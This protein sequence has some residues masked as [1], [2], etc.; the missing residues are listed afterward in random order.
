MG[1][2]L[3]GHRQGRVH[4]A[5]RA[6]AGKYHFHFVTSSILPPPPPGESPLIS[7]P[8]LSPGR[9]RDAFSYSALGAVI[10]RDTLSTIP[11]SPRVIINAVPP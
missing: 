1:L 11:I 5:R 3:L 2:K 9:R 7:L 6:A 10:C 8:V 4:V